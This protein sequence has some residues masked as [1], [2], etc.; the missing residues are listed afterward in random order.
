MKHQKMVVSILILI[1]IFFNFTNVVHAS[2]F[3]E[4]ETS[5][6]EDTI[7]KDEGRIV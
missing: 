5:E 3:T 4:E 6:I 2:L 7:D 1:L